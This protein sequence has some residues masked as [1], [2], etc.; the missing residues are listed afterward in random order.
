MPS[1]SGRNIASEFY[2]KHFTKRTYFFQVKKCDDNRCPF[3]D[4]LTGSKI[5]DFQDPIP[6]DDEEGVQRY[7]IGKDKKEKY[8][9]SLLIDAPRQPHDIPFSPTAQSAKNASLTIKCGECRKQRVIHSKH[10]LKNGECE[11]L[12]HALSGLQ[13]VCG[14]SEY[15]SEKEGILGKTFVRENLSCTMDIEINYYSAG[16]YNNICIHCETTKNL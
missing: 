2:Q 5:D 3:R 7:K 4:P 11:K 1:C 6:F 13:Y 8:L 15:D 16:I 12:K 9:P 10:V 14:S